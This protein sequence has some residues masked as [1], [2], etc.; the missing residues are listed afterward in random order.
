MEGG[1]SVCAP[2]AR[3]RRL[4]LQYRL[5]SRASSGE[6]ATAQTPLQG[7]YEQASAARRRGEL[8]RGR[9]A[10]GDAF[11]VSRSGELL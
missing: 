11:L 4:R 1:L 3:E 5:C 7:S 10:E 6:S 2:P 9:R 8:R